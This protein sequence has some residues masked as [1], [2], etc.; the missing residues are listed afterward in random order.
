MKQHKTAGVLKTMILL[1]VLPRNPGH[2]TMIGYWT[3]NAVQLNPAISI[4]QGKG[5]I[6]YNFWKYRE[7]EIA[8]G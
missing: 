8:D 5:K 6:A 1:L 7:F 3:I 2:E 4:S